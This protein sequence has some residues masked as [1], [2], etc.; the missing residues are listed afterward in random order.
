MKS[1]GPTR[2]TRSQAPAPDKVE[3]SEEEEEE[4]RLALHNPSMPPH[5]Q[6]SIP[7]GQDKRIKNKK[8]S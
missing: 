8:Q 1:E 6:R 2:R 7:L 4:E 3:E 5:N